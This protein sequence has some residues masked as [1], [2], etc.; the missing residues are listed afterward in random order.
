M[1]DELISLTLLED[2]YKESKP[3]VYRRVPV[4]ESMPTVAKNSPTSPIRSPFKIE[5]PARLPITVRPN[6]EIRKLSGSLNIR[7]TF[8]K[9]GAITKSA[10][11]LAKPPIPE[12]SM[13]IPTASSPLPFFVRGYPSMAVAALAGVPGVCSR[14]AEIEPP[15]MAEV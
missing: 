1:N 9:G 14:I 13:D 5:F 15:V 10:R 6:T 11:A 7:L 4:T 2:K 12:D 3:K 8:A